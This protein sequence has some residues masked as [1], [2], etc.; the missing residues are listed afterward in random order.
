[1]L[2]HFEPGANDIEKLINLDLADQKWWTLE[3]IQT[4]MMLTRTQ[5]FN[6]EK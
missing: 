4:K 1:M 3:E 6:I 2:Q 5:Y